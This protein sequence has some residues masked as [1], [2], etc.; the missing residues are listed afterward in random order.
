MCNWSEKTDYS[1]LV[2][3]DC[4]GT[5]I[6]WIYSLLVGDCAGANLSESSHMVDLDDCGDHHCVQLSSVWC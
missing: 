3:D 5:I 6:N 2:G 4:G 1:E